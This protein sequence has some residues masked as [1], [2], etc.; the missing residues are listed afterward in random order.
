VETDPPL[1]NRLTGGLE[2]YEDHVG[3]G[4]VVTS[5]VDATVAYAAALRVRRL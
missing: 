5:F 4:F 1:G 2:L 3:A